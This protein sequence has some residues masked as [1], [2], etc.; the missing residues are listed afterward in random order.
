M[1]SRMFDPGNMVPRLVSE[2]KGMDEVGMGWPVPPS[3]GT[4]PAFLH[5]VIES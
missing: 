3:G 1:I 5:R 2:A 4:S